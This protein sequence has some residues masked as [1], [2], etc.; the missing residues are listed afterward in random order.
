M[1]K[2]LILSIGLL[3]LINSAQA[4]QTPING[5]YVGGF[6]GASYIAEIKDVTL[7]PV[8]TL[9]TTTTTTAIKSKVG[10]DFSL[11]YGYRIKNKYRVE[12]ELSSSLNNPAS[13]NINSLELPNDIYGVNGNLN[14]TL[15][16]FLNA[17][18]DMFAEHGDYHNTTPYFGIGIGQAYT[19]TNIR[20]YNNNVL[21]DS[22]INGKQSVSVVQGIFGASYFLDDYTSLG[23]DYR[24]QRYSQLTALGQSYYRNNINMTFKFVLGG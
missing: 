6:F 4:L 9:T 24:I 19:V 18:V 11:Q 23:L 8:S 16:L 20:I 15:I 13:M 1:D 14:S 10:G 17:Y 21:L 2:K 22:P 3:S 7:P 12:A 5:P